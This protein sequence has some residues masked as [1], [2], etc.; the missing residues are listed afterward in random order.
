[1]ADGRRI[2]RMGSA[3]RGRGDCGGFAGDSAQRYWTM[4][5]SPRSGQR[6]S[7]AVRGAGGDARGCDCG[8]V[9]AGESIVRQP[10]PAGG[11]GRKKQ[12]QLSSGAFWGKMED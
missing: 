6:Y 12:V 9:G 5:L 7:A 3:M 8:G 11:R 1:M 4:G 10:D 2:G